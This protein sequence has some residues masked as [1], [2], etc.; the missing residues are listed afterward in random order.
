LLFAACSLITAVVYTQLPIDDG[1]MLPLGFP[2]DFFATG[3]FAGMGI[4]LTENFPTRIGTSGQGCSYNFG[5]GVAGF[6][7]TFVDPSSATLPSDSASALPP[8]RTGSSSSQL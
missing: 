1:L 8:A 7:P 5:R 6:H 3:I 4:R 2:L